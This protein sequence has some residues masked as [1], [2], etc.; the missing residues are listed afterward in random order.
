MEWFRKKLIFTVTSF[1]SNKFSTIRLHLM[2]DSLI[3]CY[4]LPKLLVQ[5]VE[6]VNNFVNSRIR[7]NLIAQIIYLTKNLVIIQEQYIHGKHFYWCLQRKL[8]AWT[9]AIFGE[10]I[11]VPTWFDWCLYVSFAKIFFFRSMI[12]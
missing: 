6:S 4:A 2:L 10:K 8:N 11:L 12:Y 5:V 3:I 7:W 9:D 1:V